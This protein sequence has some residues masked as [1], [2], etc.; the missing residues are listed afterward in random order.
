MIDGSPYLRHL[1]PPWLRSKGK[2][3]GSRYLEQMNVAP[4]G[5]QWARR[6]VAA[7]DHP[8]GYFC[9]PETD[10]TM[11]KRRG[12]VIRFT[13]YLHDLRCEPAIERAM[14]LSGLE[15]ASTVRPQSSQ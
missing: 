11:T 14:C 9:Q 13:R 6:D 15:P 12:A 4:E 1:R 2:R 3:D 8:S 7:E 5:R 10:G